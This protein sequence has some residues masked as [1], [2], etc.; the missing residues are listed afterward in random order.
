MEIEIRLRKIRDEEDEETVYTFLFLLLEKIDETLYYTPDHSLSGTKNLKITLYRLPMRET[1]K[2]RSVLEAELIDDGF[3]RYYEIRKSKLETRHKMWDF[4]PP[5]FS[6]KGQAQIDKTRNFNLDIQKYVGGVIIATYKTMA[7]FLEKETEGMEAPI[8]CGA[9]I[10]DATLKQLLTKRIEEEPEPETHPM[11]EDDLIREIMSEPMY[12][13]DARIEQEAVRSRRR[14][15]RELNPR[16]P[17][18]E[19]PK[20]G[21][22]GFIVPNWQAPPRPPKRKVNKNP[23]LYTSEDSKFLRE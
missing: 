21:P 19:K 3:I 5:K 7:R 20:P 22:N 1:Y 18:V 13:E 23:V 12:N 16:H 8:T 6:K 11:T 4:T 14:R 15:N 2:V 10:M 17:P 9:L